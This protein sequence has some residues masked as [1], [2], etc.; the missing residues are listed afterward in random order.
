MLYIQY[1]IYSPNKRTED[2]VSGNDIKPIYE[3]GNYF[4]ISMYAYVIYHSDQV[5]VINDFVD[6]G[7]LHVR[8]KH[9]YRIIFV[10]AWAAV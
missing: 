10:L 8:K 2:E 6:S 5:L 1:N 9:G 3:I 7:P 4:T